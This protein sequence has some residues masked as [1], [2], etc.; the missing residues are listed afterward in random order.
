MKTH[1][2][3]DRRLTGRIDHAA[4][5]DR[6]HITPGATTRKAP[7]AEEL[8]VGNAGD[9]GQRDHVPGRQD[10]RRDVLRKIFRDQ[11]RDPR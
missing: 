2:V 7:E 4:M 1:P 11:H 9:P 5:P 3:H 8:T 10:R 6:D